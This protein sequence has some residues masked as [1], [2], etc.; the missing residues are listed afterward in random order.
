MLPRMGAPSSAGTLRR[1]LLTLVVAVAVLAAIGASLEWGVVRARMARVGP[2]LLVV[3]TLVYLPPWLIRGVRWRQLAADLGDRIP[4]WPATCLATVGNMLNLVLPAKAGDLLWTHAAH[5]RW[6]VPYGRGVVG[7]FG[8]RVLDLGVLAALGA[9]ALVAVPEGRQEHGSSVTLAVGALVLG[10]GVALALFVR[11]RL[12][13]RLMIGPLARLRPL[14][15]A[16]IDPVDAL[17]RSP[18]RVALHLATTAVIWLN[19][20]LMTWIV[21]HGLGLEVS[22]AAVMFAVMVANLSKIVP[23]TPAS[24]GTYEMAGA[25]ALGVAGVGYD[26]AFA[27]I[28]VEHVLKNTLNLALGLVALWLEDLPIF[29]ADLSGVKEAWAELKRG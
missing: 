19:E 4:L 11:W 25:F 17:T 3:A 20:G 2:A 7:V 23:V 28:L 18:Q 1:R 27:A 21:V 13:S 15:D 8:G 16:L 26:D 29:S 5:L 14:H 6:G 24:F 22:F 10:G 9:L 12:A